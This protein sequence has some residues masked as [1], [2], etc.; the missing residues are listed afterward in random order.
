MLTKI[1]AAPAL[2]AAASLMATPAA[3]VEL[4]RSSSAPV[5]SPVEAA[6]NYGPWGGVGIGGGWGWGGGGYRGGHHR[7]G[8]ASDILTGVLI[9]GT[10][11]AAAN[12]ANRARA[13]GSYPNRYPYPNSYP[14][15][16][17][18][19]Y[20]DRSNPYRPP[21][22]DRQGDWR[23]GGPQGLEGA[24]NMCL[25]EVERNARARE[26]TRVERT[27]NGW[28][29]TGAMADGAAFNCSIGG[30]GRIESVDVGGRAQ[31]YG[32]ADRRYDDQRYRPA[33]GADSGAAGPQPA[34]PGGPLPGEDAEA[35]AP[36]N[37][38]GS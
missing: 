35:Q 15:P 22:Q 13:R 24:A 38:P 29:V 6:S 26:V 34:Y 30:D 1:L 11:A 28:L 2:L 9:L 25:R 7:R 33:A 12:A 21:N 3:A 8:G 19:P 16:N 14:N 31:S 18:Y 10:I 17:R 20:P 23:P 5:G 36:G 27:A 4:A 37:P 32:Q